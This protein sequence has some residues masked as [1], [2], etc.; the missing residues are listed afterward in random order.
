MIQKLIGPLPVIYGVKKVH[1]YLSHRAGA[2]PQSPGIDADVCLSDEEFFQMIIEQSES[3]V[4][5]HPRLS[6]Q[7]VRNLLSANTKSLSR[8]QRLLKSILE[9][10]QVSRVLTDKNFKSL[11]DMHNYRRKYKHYL[12]GKRVIPLGL[13]GPFTGTE[14]TK[15]SYAAAIGSKSISLTLPGLLGY[16]LPSFFFFH[17]S[18]Y[19]APDKFK[20]LCQLGKYTLGAPVWIISTIADKLMA[21][22]EETFF[23]EEVPIDMVNTG[24]TIPPDVGDYQQLKDILEDVKKEFGK[25]T[26]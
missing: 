16:A 6:N 13:L 21:P 23:G 8:D 2:Q 7:E 11:E 4:K 5:K 15:M 19:Y 14:L 10:A 12:R 1:N 25:K 20:P 24:G 18:Y 9:E 26:Y 17:M 3:S 22:V